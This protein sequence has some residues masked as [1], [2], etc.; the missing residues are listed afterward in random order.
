MTYLTSRLME[1]SSLAAISAGVASAALIPSPYSWICIFIA[2]V[3]TMLPD[4]RVG[5]GQ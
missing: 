1:R 3:Q 5:G 4:G 2:V